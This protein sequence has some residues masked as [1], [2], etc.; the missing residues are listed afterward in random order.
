MTINEM[1]AIRSNARN[2]VVS[3]LND[4]FLGIKHVPHTNEYYIETEVE[5]VEAP[6]YVKIV[7]SVVAWETSGNVKAFDFEERCAEVEKEWQEKEA[8]KAER[9]EKKSNAPEKVDNTAY[10][11]KVLGYVASLAEPATCADIYEM[12][13]W[14]AGE[15]KGKLASA[16]GRLRKDGKVAQEIGK[17]KKKVWKIA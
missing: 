4:N 8:R 2:Q 7:P 1:N 9:A 16:L 11:L 13:E 14:D 15:T 3:V 12:N 17:D 10:D 6:V 5:G